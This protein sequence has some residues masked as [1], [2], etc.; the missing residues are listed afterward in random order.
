MFL[1]TGQ[2]SLVRESW[3][4]KNHHHSGS[5]CLLMPERSIKCREF[6]VW[7]DGDSPKGMTKSIRYYGP[8]KVLDGHINVLENATKALKMILNQ[9]G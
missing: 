5:I 4:K 7:C 1:K 6:N 8:C 9:R 2:L 3:G